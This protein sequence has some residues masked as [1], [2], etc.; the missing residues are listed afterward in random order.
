MISDAILAMSSLN[1]IAGS[2]THKEFEIIVTGHQI[3]CDIES[4]SK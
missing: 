2:L 3:N 4:L 1:V